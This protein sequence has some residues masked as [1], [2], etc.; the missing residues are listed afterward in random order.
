MTNWADA[1][2][3]PL[4][5]A[6]EMA[7]GLIEIRDTVKFGDA[8]IKLQAQ[9]MAAQQGALA[10]HQREAAMA[11]EIRDLKTRMTELEAWDAEKQRYELTNF[12]RETFA[13]VLKPSM[14]GG[15]PSHRICPACYQKGHKSILQFRHQTATGQDKYA[16]PA[17]KTDFFFGEYSDPPVIKTR[18]RGRSWTDR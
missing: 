12:G 7:Q 1:I 2:M 5:S 11:E 10:A 17:C 13:Y 3:S 18:G 14:S 8:I 16:C 9:I 15:E 6:G 4:K